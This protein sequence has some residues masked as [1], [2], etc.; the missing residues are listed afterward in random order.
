MC[1][2]V[3][4]ALLLAVT[5]QGYESYDKSKL[6]NTTEE[7]VQ[8]KVRLTALMTLGTRSTHELKFAEV[9]QALGLGSDSEVEAW[10]VRAIG[11]VGHSP[12]LLYLI[13]FVMGNTEKQE[14]EN[15]EKRKLHQHQ[16]IRPQIEVLPCSVST[17]WPS[18]PCPARCR[19]L[20]DAC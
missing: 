20:Q 16:H 17:P 7:D 14:V 6:E 15:M 12:S 5:V 18:V 13:S 19:Q 4:D 11:K 9:Q 2:P 1:V 3:T 10:V 8:T